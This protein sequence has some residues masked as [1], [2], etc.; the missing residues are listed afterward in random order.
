MAVR[1]S[2]ASAATSTN[3]PT[4]VKEAIDDLLNEA[5]QQALMAGATAVQSADSAVIDMLLAP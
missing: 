5:G 4:P 1:E 3:A 2:S